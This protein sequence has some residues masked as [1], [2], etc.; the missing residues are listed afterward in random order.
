MKKNILAFFMITMLVGMADQMQAM[1]PSLE[2]KVSIERQATLVEKWIGNK[3]EQL[4]QKDEGPFEKVKIDYVID[5]DTFVLATGEKVRIIGVDAPEDTKKVEEFG[6]EAT[7]Y[8]KGILEGNTV[9]LEKDVSETDKYGRLLRY[10]WMEN[11]NVDKPDME[12]LFNARIVADGYAEPATFP[13]D[14]KYADT[15]KEKANEARTKGK[16]LWEK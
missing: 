15:F 2:Q 8:A 1:E 14:V 9:Y 7:A 5:G 12:L 6:P 3:K 13:P 4:T 11:P 16:G 10:V